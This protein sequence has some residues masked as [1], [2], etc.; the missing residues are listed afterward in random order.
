M[1][2]YRYWIRLLFATLKS[3][4]MGVTHYAFTFKWRKSRLSSEKQ[5][6]SPWL[7][8]TKIYSKNNKFGG[9]TETQTRIPSLEGL[10]SVQLSY[11]PMVP[12]DRFELSS[13]LQN[14]FTV[15]R[16]QPLTHLGIKIGANGGTCIHSLFITNEV[17]CYWATSAIN[18]L[19]PA[20]RFELSSNPYR[21]LI[22]PLNYTGIT[23]NLGA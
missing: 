3:L 20:D 5:L 11:R 17:L 1:T 19:D 23:K 21:G 9:S 10:Y 12:R 4:W 14:G 16:F 2:Q 13:F 22:L 6:L 18:I 15:R 7:L 8:G